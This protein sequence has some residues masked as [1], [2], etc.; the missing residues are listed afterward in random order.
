MVRPGDMRPRA[1]TPPPVARRNDADHPPADG[2]DA[3]RL[4]LWLWAARFYKS[5]SLASAAVDIGHARLNDQR[6]KPAHG[7]RVG[8]RV[9]VRREGV[10][11][12]A[13]VTGLAGRRGSATDAARLYRESEASRQAREADAARRR[14]AALAAPRFPGRPTKRQRRKLE[15]FLEEP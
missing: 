11:C 10:V 7:V 2:P 5:R 4:D 1:T 15:G 12:D 8:D 13:T 9:T 14:D 3:L 6:V